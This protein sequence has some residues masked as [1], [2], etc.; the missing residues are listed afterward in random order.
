MSSNTSAIVSPSSTT[1]SDPQSEPVNST[2]PPNVASSTSDFPSILPFFS[3]TVITPLPFVTTFSAASSISPSQSLP[4]PST[5]ATTP[6]ATSTSTDTSVSVTETTTSGTDT[7]P[8][9]PPTSVSSNDGPSTTSESSPSD[10]GATSVP[11]VTSTT[12]ST[13]ESTSSSTTSSSTRSPRPSTSSTLTSSSSL[14][15]SI[16]KVAAPSTTSTGD[17][18]ANS[19]SSS[20]PTPTTTLIIQP[21][22]TA[23]P[24]P[25]S[26]TLSAP[27]SPPATMSNVTAANNSGGNGNSNSTM[28]ISGAATNS[29]KKTALIAG[30][31]TGMLLLF[32]LLASIAFCRWRSRRKH[33][34]RHDA[35]RRASAD[36][37]RQNHGPSAAASTSSLVPRVTHSMI[38]DNSPPVGEKDP[39]ADPATNTQSLEDVMSPYTANTPA[40]A[41]STVAENTGQWM[42]PSSW[43]STLLSAARTPLPPYAQT[44]DSNVIQYNVR[45]NPEPYYYEQI[46]QNPYQGPLVPNRAMPTPSPSPP[47]VVP[48]INVT[49]PESNRRISRETLPIPL[50]TPVADY[51]PWNPFRSSLRSSLNSTTSSASKYSV[52][53][54]T[55]VPPVPRIPSSYFGI[56]NA[57]P[58]PSTLQNRALIF[59]NKGPVVRFAPPTPT[60]PTA[61]MSLVPQAAE[62][63]GDNIDMF[64]DL[65][66]KTARLSSVNTDREMFGSPN[67]S[68]RSS[69]NHPRSAFDAR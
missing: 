58:G 16:S 60:T 20:S 10:P 52:P 32:L 37:I 40:V 46:Q 14:N 54:M 42:E 69:Q 67:E 24:A 3:S 15:F 51:T 5:M 43:Q 22:I 41:P 50:V 23:I 2:L 26:T 47:L 55:E 7:L 6:T 31:T 25:S 27:S 17:R 63:G 21:P 9:S 29:H 4:S 19:S 8:T 45:Q 44:S 59:T 33:S 39:I 66:P 49:I 68:Y 11:L 57:G 28:N 62:R 56:G 65:Q 34:A 30:L 18:T 36:W 38:W 61:H 13:S 1:D 12:E 35:I 53:S 48:A 64:L